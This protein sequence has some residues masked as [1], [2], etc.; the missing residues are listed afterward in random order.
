MPVPSLQGK[1][2]R[3]TALQAMAASVLAV[4]LGACGS[5]G[6]QDES[7]W[8]AIAEAASTDQPELTPR[9]AAKELGLHLGPD[10][11]EHPSARV[12]ARLE[13]QIRD[14]FAAGRTELVTGW[15]LARTE[16]LLSVVAADRG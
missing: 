5:E 12:H 15:L 3:R 8:S 14:D 6:T 11:V 13:Q 4:G 1:I 16:V 10:D 2:T 7:F 9:R